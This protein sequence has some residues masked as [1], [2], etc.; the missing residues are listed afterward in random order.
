MNFY[1]VGIDVVNILRFK[2]IINKNNTFKQRIFS[3]VE[4]NYCQKKKNNISCFAMRYAAKEAFSKALGTG[5]SKGI[6]F[7]DIEIKNDKLGKPD[8]SIKGKS[9]I[10]VNKILKKKKYKSFIS[11]SDDKPCAVAVVIILT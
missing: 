8:I 10:I 1:G 5:I 2:S 3:N 9:K 7:K 6:L 4:I 11:L